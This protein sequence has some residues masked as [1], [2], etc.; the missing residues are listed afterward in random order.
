MV[1]SQVQ[2]QGKGQ[3]MNQC[4][5]TETA[6]QTGHLHNNPITLRHTMLINALYFDF[7]I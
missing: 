3:D 1:N 2:Q 7:C 4:Q 5:Q 6:Q